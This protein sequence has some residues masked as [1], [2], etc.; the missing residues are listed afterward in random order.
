ME[1][2]EFD[3]ENYDVITDPVDFQDIESNLW[4]RGFHI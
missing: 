4:D 2:I 3:H 1:K